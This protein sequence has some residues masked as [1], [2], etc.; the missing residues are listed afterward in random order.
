MKSYKRANP[1]ELVSFFSLS[2]CKWGTSVTPLPKCSQVGA[3]W[4]SWYPLWCAVCCCCCALWVGCVYMLASRRQMRAC[5]SNGRSRCG[6]DKRNFGRHS[7]P[8]LASSPPYSTQCTKTSLL[9]F[10]SALSLCSRMSVCNLCASVCAGQVY[11]WKLVL[12]GEIPSS[13]SVLRYS[14][15]QFFLLSDFECDLTV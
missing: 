12:I 9:S 8:A 6:R 4:P 14:E 3:R 11:G 13:E 2:R 7:F 15:R 10:Q 1:E 5:C